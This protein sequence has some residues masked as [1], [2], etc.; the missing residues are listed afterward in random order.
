MVRTA[1]CW[2]EWTCVLM[3]LLLGSPSSGALAKAPPLQGA[4]AGGAHTGDLGAFLGRAL[5][6]R[7]R[8]LGCVVLPPLNS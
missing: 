6:R 3:V 5:A 8:P 2:K 7:C 4:T 1:V